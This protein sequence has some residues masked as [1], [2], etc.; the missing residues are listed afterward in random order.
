MRTES[1]HQ[2]TPRPPWLPAVI[3][4]ESGSFLQKGLSLDCCV[5]GRGKGRT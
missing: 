4:W 5:W 1:H 2:R 3:I